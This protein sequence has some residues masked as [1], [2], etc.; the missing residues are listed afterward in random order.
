MNF[1]DILV[2]RANETYT[3]ARYYSKLP[4]SDLSVLVTP[5]SFSYE[6]VNPT[7]YRYSRILGNVITT[8]G[9]DTTVKTRA[10]ISFAPNGYV[11]LKDGNLYLISSVTVDTSDTPKQAARILLIPRGTAKILRLI[12][13]AD[14]WGIGGKR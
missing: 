5:E 12:K 3:G 2:G 13:T 1:I 4:S 6:Y 8:D 11:T 9:A 7:E 14:P 10:P